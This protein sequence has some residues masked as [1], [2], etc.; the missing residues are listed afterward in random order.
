[1]KSSN[2]LLFILLIGFSICAPA[3]TDWRPPEPRPFFRVQSFPENPHGDSKQPNPGNLRM[4]M[5]IPADLPPESPLVLALH[6]CGQTAEAFM[7]QTGWTTLA[8]KYKFVVVFPEQTQRRDNNPDRVG[9]PW[10]CFNWAGYRGLRMQRGQG[11]NQSIKEMVDFVLNDPGL[12]IDKKKVYITGLSAGGAMS[13]L[14]LA[15]WPEIFAA[16]APIAGVPYRCA[17]NV[18]SVFKCMGLNRNF[19]PR[20][21]CTPAGT[22]CMAD[23]VKHPPEEWAALARKGSRKFNGEWP[24]IMIWHG[25]RDQ[26][27]DDANLTETMKQW[28]ALHKTDQQPDNQRAQLQ[29]GHERH[30]YKEYRKDGKLVVAT[31]RVMGLMHGLSIDSR[32]EADL[33][34]VE[35]T[36]PANGGY[37]YDYML[38]TPFYIAEFF[39][40]TAS[41][42][43][44][45]QSKTT[46]KTHEQ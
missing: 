25:S 8:D 32:K 23:E 46:E 2:T 27:T 15:T 28:T 43:T 31:V 10:R 16:G 20:H 24:R 38:H 13:T 35:I 4:Y 1:M 6:G 3:S 7:V 26:M 39:G 5:H 17:D 36:S 12:S 9:N 21:G 42:P 45:E 19:I 11:E 40:L 18:D 30:E 41:K 44:S 14:M 34:G 29:E 33:G 22:A 37:T